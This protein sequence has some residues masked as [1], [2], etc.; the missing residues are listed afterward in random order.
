MLFFLLIGGASFSQSKEGQAP[1]KEDEDSPKKKAETKL[2]EVITTDSIP[3]SELLN[4]AINWVKTENHKYVKKGG[5]SSGSKA[6]CIA[7]FIIK[8]KELN[9]EV[10]FTGKI[11]MKVVIECKDA[12]Y[13][14]TVSEI[15]HISKSGKANGG[16]VDNAVAECGSMTMKD[17]TW[18]KLKGEAMR[19][20]AQVVAD[21]KEAMQKPTTEVKTE[22]W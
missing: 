10:D 21:I 11:T 6:E 17:M 8:P 20:A 4:R 18:R 1:A 22:E 14:Y 13:R 2:S 19:D 15:K 3:A 5:A 7:S 9:P 12:K 16:S